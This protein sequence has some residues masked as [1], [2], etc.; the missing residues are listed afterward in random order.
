[1]KLLLTLICVAAA[2]PASARQLEITPLASFSTAAEIDQTAATVDDL[3]I[4]RGFTWGAQAS[5]FVTTHLG[6]EALWAYQSTVMSMSADSGTSDLF[7]MKTNQIHGNV[8]YQFRDGLAVVRPFV[9]GGI[10]ATL[11]SAPD[12]ESETKA[13]WT[14]GGG[15]KWFVQPHVGLKAHARYTPTELSDTSATVC[16]PFGFCQG[17][18]TK[19]EFAGGAV[20]RF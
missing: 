19:L 10:G 4:S 5:Y 18:L 6:V 17:S 7:S 14:V 11:F 12:L 13:S 3:S 20:F 8:V 1:M 15:L 2:V 9:F 16:D